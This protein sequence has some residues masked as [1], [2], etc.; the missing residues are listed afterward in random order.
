M[1]TERE[2]ADAF[3]RL[4]YSKHAEIWKKTLWLGVPAEKLPFDLWMYQEILWEVRPD[5]ILET[6][7]F[8]GGSALFLASITDLLGGTKARIVSV[9][10]DPQPGRPVHPRITYLEDSSTAPRVVAKVKEL[11]QGAERPLVILDSDHTRDH[12]LREMELYAPLVASGSYLIVEDGNINGHPVFPEFGPGPTE[13]IQ[14][15]LK[16]HPE[17][18]V[19]RSR[20]RFMVTFNPGGYLKRK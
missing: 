6:G 15:F 12:V 18:E 10:N 4:Y 7:T 16:S 3:H 8:L 5:F 9:D 17:F 19:D 14:I 13:A 11:A 20:E 1:S 2:V